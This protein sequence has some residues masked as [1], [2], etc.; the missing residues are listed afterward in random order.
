MLVIRLRGLAPLRK[1]VAWLQTGLAA[2]RRLYSCSP[3]RTEMGAPAGER[4][5]AASEE[6]KKKRIEAPYITLERV[7]TSEQQRTLEVQS[8]CKQR[9]QAKHVPLRLRTHTSQE[10]FSFLVCPSGGGA[11]FSPHFMRRE[12]ASCMHSTAPNT[13]TCLPSVYCACNTMDGDVSA[14]CTQKRLLL[15]AT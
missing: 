14:T 5:L 12:R 9:K 7:T 11:L 10:I 8:F 2:F 6:P 3:T 15:K 13:Q 1:Q 4:R